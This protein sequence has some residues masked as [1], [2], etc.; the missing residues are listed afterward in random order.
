[1]NSGGVTS[2]KNKESLGK[3]LFFLYILAVIWIILF[4]FQLHIDDIKLLSDFN[5][6]TVNLQPFQ[7]PRRINGEVDYSEIIYNVLIFIPFGIL[8]PVVSKK[9]GWLRKIGGILLFTI[10]LETS[11]YLFSLGACDITDVIT[12]LTGGLIGLIS[13]STLKKWIEEE[14]L[15]RYL[16]PIGYILFIFFL[17][18]FVIIMNIHI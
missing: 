2:L 9:M 14:T 17:F 16:I 4:K 3:I 12:N 11:Q 10:L 13:Y 6:G 15:D 1:M 7:A 5:F 18:L 8:L